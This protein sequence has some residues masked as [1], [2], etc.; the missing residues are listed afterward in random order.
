MSMKG[1]WLSCKEAMLA[2]FVPRNV[3][4]RLVVEW[5]VVLLMCA[6]GHHCKYLDEQNMALH[7]CCFGYQD[8]Q[9]LIAVMAGRVETGKLLINGVWARPMAFSVVGS[10]VL[11][12]PADVPSAN[13]AT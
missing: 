3:A 6:N 11:A 10:G 12:N 8:D 7:P 9:K 2:V 4:V 1:G 5:L 13:T